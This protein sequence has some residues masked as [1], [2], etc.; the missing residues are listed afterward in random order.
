MNDWNINATQ[1]SSNV[2][3]NLNKLY[4]PTGS[5]AT[6]SLTHSLHPTQHQHNHT[7]PIYENATE[8]YQYSI[9]IRVDKYISP[10]LPLQKP[11]PEQNIP[12]TQPL[13]SAL[14]RPFYI[15]FFLGA[16]PSS[17]ATWSFAPTLIAS[18][19]VLYYPPATLT[20]PSPSP[21]T[22]TATTNP[23][24]PT[25]PPPTPQITTY[26]Q[27]PLAH[28]L[29]RFNLTSAHPHSVIPLLTQ[30]LHWRVQD[31]HDRAVE[32]G[33]VESL[34]VFVVGRKVV[35]KAAGHSFPVYGGWK[36]Y[37]EAT[38]GKAG[39]LGEGEGM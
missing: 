37:R 10:P 27:L 5:I 8:E 36:I 30:H 6:R 16:V 22:K 23:I 34:K 12:L 20:S 13:R 32:T 3:T 18:H 4:N 24:P 1:L 17:Q 38:D 19:S 29:L 15:H 28:A 33:A 14:N 11:S 26:G 35:S 2:R 31:F 9:N 39:G 21:N 7:F 25:N